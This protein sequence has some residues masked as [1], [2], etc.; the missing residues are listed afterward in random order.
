[1]TPAAITLALLTAISFPVS[2]SNAAAQALVDRG[3]FYYYAYDRGDAERSFAA[4]AALDPHLAM[5]YWGEA[6]AD[7]PDLNTPMAQDGFVRGQAAIAQA[8][9]LEPYASEVERLYIEAMRQRYAGTY[10]DLAR[11]N[12]AYVRSMIALSNDRQTQRDPV[13]GMLTAEALLEQ[14]GLRWEGAQPA[15]PA[16]REALGVVSAALRDRPRDVMANHLC[17]HV[18]DEAPDRAAAL[19]CARFLDE[20]QFVPQA[21][22]L[23]HMPAHYWIE[24]GNYS[25]AIKS[26]E[27][28]HALF[29]QLM[30]LPGRSDDHDKYLKHDV[31][32]GYSASMMLGNFAVAGVWA[33]RM[34][35]AYGTDF[36]A[37]T[38]LRFD[39]F[40]QAYAS[41]S[42][43]DPTALAIRGYAAVQLG[44]LD[45]AQALAKKLH[46]VAV[47]GYLGDLFFARLAEAQGRDDEAT[48]FIDRAAEQQR[49]AFTGELIPLMPALEARAGLALRRGRFDE[50][51]SDF[52]AALADF[53]NDPRAL[54]GLAAALR[55]A[56]Q[57]ATAAQT[58]FEALW[59]GADTTLSATDL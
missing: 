32:V 15:T 44:R 31:Y 48:R 53:P 11:D 45:D 43:S 27:R 35:D 9:A 28:A 1:M 56:N 54:F 57:S 41:A 33:K 38:A 52:R 49:G 21:E 16:T 3:L 7:G 46:A 36:D 17:L 29:E 47:T 6:L 24:S 5:A 10:A 37:L 19:P 18:Y 42:G 34:D 14:G 51:A 59:T 22:H 8:V 39:R 20:Q 2:T 30:Q 25:N 12:G 26:S 13:A 23:A 4:A 40:A 58:A 50:A 55:A